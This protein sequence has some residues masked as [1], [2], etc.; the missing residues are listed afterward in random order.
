MPST[1]P[2][3]AASSAPVPDTGPARHRQ[4]GSEGGSVTIREIRHHREYRMPCQDA[5]FGRSGENLPGE[6]LSAVPMPSQPAGPPQESAEDG[7]PTC[8]SVRRRAWLTWQLADRATDRLR[9]AGAALANLAQSASLHAGVTTARSKPGTKHLAAAVLQLGLFG[10]QVAAGQVA[11]DSLRAACARIAVAAAA[12]RAHL[13]P[14]AGSQ[15]IA[16]AL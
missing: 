10:R 13:H 5:Q 2:T 15:R 9:R 6:R 4:S 16:L 7:H 8:R 12:W 14:V 1:S 11:G 3:P